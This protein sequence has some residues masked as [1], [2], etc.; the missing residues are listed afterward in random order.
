MLPEKT[1]SYETTMSDIISAI[2]AV[3][4]TAMLSERTSSYETTLS[5]ARSAT[6]AAPH[7]PP[8]TAAQNTA[9]LPEKISVDS[10]RPLYGP[11]AG[12]TRVTVTGQSLNMF[13]VA[14]VYFGQH[15]GLLDK[16]SA[17]ENT[18]FATTPPVNETARHLEIELVLNDGSRINTNHTFEYR[19]NPVFAD[20]R[21]RD[22]LAVG[23]TEVTVTGSNLDSV[24]E[25]RTTVTVVITRFYDDRNS[26]TSKNETDSEPCELPQANA[27]GSEMLCRMPEVILPDDL[28][29]Q[30]E[31][32]DSEKAHHAGT[33]TEGP[34]VAAYLSSDGR[35]RADIYVGLKLDGLTRYQDISSVDPDIKM[36]F[37]LP[38]T[39]FCKSDSL[40]FDPSKRKFIEIKGQHLRR[41]CREVDYDIRLGV[42]ACVLVSLTDNQVDCRPPTDRPDTLV[43]DTF[44]HGDTISLQLT[45]G[46]AQYQCYCVNYVQQDDIA[47]TVG[48]TV[49]LGLLF[50]I[51]IIAVIIGVLMHR[52]SQSKQAG[53]EVSVDNIGTSKDLRVEDEHYSRRLPGDNEQSRDSDVIDRQGPD[54]HR[55][56]YV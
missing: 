26:T 29:Q 35:V 9:V 5:D 38:P 12:G 11:V 16:H 24:A 8:T 32:N 27:N 17:E 19:G 10:V 18:V 6:T 42:A 55:E 44:C 56:S 28:N 13:T 50:I 2:T 1:S 47:L 33:Y 7:R 25:P 51:L 39:I 48:L 34:G 52:R 31:K 3:P 20:I 21:P 37:A 40:D 49:G 4:N 15:Q 45:I 36:Q 53:Q 14:A 46:N 54:D 30:L 43:N 22:H 23:G 41:G